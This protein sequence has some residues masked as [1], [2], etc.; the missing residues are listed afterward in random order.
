MRLM[1]IGEKNISFSWNL[2]KKRIG[3]SELHGNKNSFE[4]HVSRSYGSTQIFW[5]KIKLQLRK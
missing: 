2:A 5:N 3:I 4:I 1:E